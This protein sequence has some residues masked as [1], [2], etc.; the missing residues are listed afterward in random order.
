MMNIILF[1]RRSGTLASIRLGRWQL[2]FISVVTLLALPGT[3]LYVGKSVGEWQARTQAMPEE[4]KREIE[5]SKEEVAHAAQTAR[6]EINVLATRLALLQAQSIRLNALG[7]RLVV[8][9]KLD[10]RE[11]DFSQPPGQG[12]PQD[13]GEDSREIAVPDF[14]RSLEQLAVDLDGREERLRT[15]EA[16]F[17]RRNLAEATIP[18]GRPVH[19]GWVASFFGMRTDP[20]T[21]LFEFHRGLDFAGAEGAEVTAV[22]AGIVTWSGERPGY[23]NMVEI[24]HGNGYIT[25][26]AHNRENLVKAGDVVEKGQVIGLMGSSGRSTGPHVHFEVIKNGRAV[27]PT[28]Y[29]R[30]G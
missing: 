19:Q 26:Y 14:I 21:G 4:W 22:A 9:A 13:G 18:T 8:A 20:F 3:A 23:G 29:T 15:L 12:G 17:M 16:I 2:A 28:R 30:A 5:R 25:R 7:Q 24:D 6:E 1:T 10:Q 27:D 11:F